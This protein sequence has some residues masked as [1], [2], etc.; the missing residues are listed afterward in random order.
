MQAHTNKVQLEAR[1][2]SFGYWKVVKAT[3][4]EAIMTALSELHAKRW[5]DE[6]NARLASG[7]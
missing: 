6:H 7:L 3:N 2:D 5:A 1:P 4:G